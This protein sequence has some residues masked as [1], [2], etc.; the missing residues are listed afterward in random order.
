[1]A[2]DVDQG[3]LFIDASWSYCGTCN[4]M[5]D[6]HQDHHGTVPPGMTSQPFR[7]GCGV[8]FTALSS[9]YGG[10]DIRAAAQRMRP[11]LPWQP[12]MLGDE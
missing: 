8:R 7:P 6:P 11:D 10:Q 1:M 5:A 2:T 9:H 4:R 12:R 3:V